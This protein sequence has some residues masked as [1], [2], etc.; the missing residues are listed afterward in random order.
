MLYLSLG[1]LALTLLSWPVAWFARRRFNAPMPLSGS[2][3]RAYRATRL[4]SGLVILV[5]VGWMVAISML[6]GNVENFAGSFD[7]LL[8]LLQIGGVIVF[9]GGVAVAGWNAWLTW[10]DGRGWKAKTWSV[11]VVVAALVVLYVAFTFNL[12][13]MT[14]NY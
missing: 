6:F 11:L 5:L 3:L 9:V 8:W 10:H 12:M 1:V 13:A 4:V 2:A 7:V 14:V